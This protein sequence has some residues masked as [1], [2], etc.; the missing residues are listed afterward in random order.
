LDGRGASVLIELTSNSKAHGWLSVGF[1]V[2]A[3]EKAV[4]LL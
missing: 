1:F 2:R 4:T 3:L